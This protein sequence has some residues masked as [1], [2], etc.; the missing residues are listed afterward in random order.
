[1]S[2]HSKMYRKI[3]L[4]VSP[5][6]S[7]RSAYTASDA[8]HAVW[9]ASIGTD[10]N[11]LTETE[12]HFISKSG[13]LDDSKALDD[14]TQLGLSRL[15]CALDC[16]RIFDTLHAAVSHKWGSDLMSL[17]HCINWDSERF[18]ACSPAGL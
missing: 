18:P 11:L 12:R 2:N 9:V 4:P 8:S 5:N 7:R 6:C 17:G 3:N 16:G 15:P 1:M 14:V 10:R 13:F